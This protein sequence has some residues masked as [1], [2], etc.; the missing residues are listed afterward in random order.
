[1]KRWIAIG[2][3]L[4]LV[5]VI[6]ACLQ[7]PGEGTGLPSTPVQTTSPAVQPVTVAFCE[8]YI[9]SARSVF[10]SH[11]DQEGND[12]VF[13]YEDGFGDTSL[14]YLTVKVNAGTTWHTTEPWGV[15][16]TGRG[17]KPGKGAEFRVRGEGTAGMDRVVI[18]AHFTD[19]PSEVIRI[20]CV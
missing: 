15:L 2:I 11:P 9:S 13:A 12:I 16:G 19:G 17:T 3:T 5:A 6:P 1:M 20:G 10:V 14:E 8:E 7:A 4:V 18:T